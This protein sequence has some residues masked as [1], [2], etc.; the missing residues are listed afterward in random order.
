METNVQLM[1]SSHIMDQGTTINFDIEEKEIN[2]GLNL[3]LQQLMPLNDELQLVEQEQIR[4][5]LQENYRDF[6]VLFNRCN[7][8]VRTVSHKMENIYK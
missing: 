1:I 8:E 5:Q 6:K 2:L 3:I 7:D 4:E